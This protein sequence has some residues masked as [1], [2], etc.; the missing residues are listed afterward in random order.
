MALTYQQ[1][2]DFAALVR[3]EIQSE[4]NTAL[5]VGTLSEEIIKRLEELSIALEELETALEQKLENLEETFNQKLENTKTALQTKIDQLKTYVDQKITELTNLLN[6]IPQGLSQE[7]DTIKQELIR[8]ANLI[9]TKADKSVLE[10]LTTGLIY[11]GKVPTINDLPTNPDTVRTGHAY[12]VESETDEHGYAYIFQAELSG[13]PPQVAWNNT[14]L[15]IFTSDIF[16]IENQRNPVNE[17]RYAA[18]MAGNV[19]GEKYLKCNGSSVQKDEYPLLQLPQS[20]LP[21]TFFLLTGTAAINGIAIHCIDGEDIISF[22]Y[23]ADEEKG[24]LRKFN[25]VTN[26]WEEFVSNITVPMVKPVCMTRA[27]GNYVVMIKN[28][29]S[30]Y[31][32][33]VINGSSFNVV[34]SDISSTNG[35]SNY[36]DKIGEFCYVNGFYAMVDYRGFLY[37]KNL[38]TGWTKLFDGNYYNIGTHVRIFDEKFV[39]TTHNSIY[40]SDATAGAES[41]TLNLVFSYNNLAYPTACFYVGEYYLVLFKHYS[42]NNSHLARAN[43]LSGWDANTII[44]TI[45]ASANGTQQ[46]AFYDNTYFVFQ[47]GIRIS[48]GTSIAGSFYTKDAPYKPS[49]AANYFPRDTFNILLYGNKIY[50]VSGAAVAVYKSNSFK[51]PIIENGWIRALE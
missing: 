44:G 7:L 18:P 47:G 8:L 49:G 45:D 20:E 42:Y 22:I 46:F 27:G 2:L 28:A 6:Q 31:S 9:N 17:I 48:L 29:T 11:K 25:K 24:T 14:F 19:F 26:E 4:A 40:V 1:L 41:L 43:S 10:N 13:E 51:L 30:S 33:I 39:V 15:T 3:D 50:T 36:G 12:I 23:N 21:D 37:S 5:R 35:F 34:Q 16:S 32:F 38:E